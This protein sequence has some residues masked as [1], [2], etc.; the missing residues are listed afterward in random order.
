MIAA[1]SNKAAHVA[2]LSTKSDDFKYWTVAKLE[3]FLRDHGLPVTGKK[4]DLV[5]RAVHSF[6]ASSCSVTNFD[7]GGPRAV[8]SPSV[9]AGGS[10]AM[11]TRCDLSPRFFCID[12]T[13]L[14]EFESDKI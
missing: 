8:S 3:A 11:I 5:A 9:N 12:A 10:K 4:D 1:N 13:L 2:D 6:I 14:C 7:K